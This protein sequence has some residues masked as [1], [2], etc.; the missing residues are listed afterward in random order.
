MRPKRCYCYVIRLLNKSEEHGTRRMYM[1]TY[2]MTGIKIEGRDLL[3][4]KLA[5]ASKMA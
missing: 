2:M 5:R 1:A 3:S 4:R